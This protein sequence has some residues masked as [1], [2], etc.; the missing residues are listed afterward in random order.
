MRSWLWRLTRTEFGRTLY[1][2]LT[3]HGVKFSPLYVYARSLHGSNGDDRPISAE[4]ITIE[5]RWGSELDA[6][7]RFE[8]LDPTDT[9]VLARANGNIVGHLFFSTARP[10]Y[11]SVVEMEMGV[12]PDTAYIWQLHVDPDHRQQRIGTA[13]LQRA[14]R[15]AARTD[16]TRTVTALVAVDNTPSQAL[17]ETT[18]FE[19][20]ELIIYGRLFGL[21][22]RTRWKSSK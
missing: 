21:T 5:S 16:E 11:A 7:G 22:H 6:T 8:D 12:E 20:T 4:G 9:A 10:V 17:F 13:L 15:V 18:G 2:T 3:Q 19:R 14:C 1:E